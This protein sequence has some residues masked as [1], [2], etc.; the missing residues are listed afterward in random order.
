MKRTRIDRYKVRGKMSSAPQPFNTFEE[1]ANAASI[2]PNTIYSAVDSHSW[3][4]ATLDAIAH[5]LGCS[6]LD[7]LTVDE[8]DDDQPPAAPAPKAS[9]AARQTQRGALAPPAATATPQQL[10]AEEARRRALLAQAEGRR[11]NDYSQR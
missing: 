9:D 2:S 11:A 10:A 6:P 5:A 3:R 1:L 4:G 8:V 7:I